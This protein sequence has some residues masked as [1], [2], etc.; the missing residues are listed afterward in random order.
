[1]TSADREKWDRIYSQKSATTIPPVDDWLLECVEELTPG[2][3]LD[4]ACGLGQNAMALANLGWDVD[5]VDISQTGLDLAAQHARSQGLEI[6]WVCADLDHWIPDKSY[7]LIVLFRFLDWATIPSIVQQ[8]LN[9]EGV[10]CYETFS[11]TQM[12]R[13]DNHLRNSQFTVQPGD[14]DQ[15]LPFLS[16]LRSENTK[17]ADRDVARFSGLLSET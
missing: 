3:A 15:Y 7:N 4:L 12:D 9:V 11:S 1:M 16:V 14:F 8:G 17:L 13:L 6:N 2:R 5:A 10:F